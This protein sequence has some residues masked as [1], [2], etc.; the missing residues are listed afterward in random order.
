MT[1]TNIKKLIKYRYIKYK[2]LASKI[3]LNNSKYKTNNNSKVNN[4]IIIE[5]ELLNQALF[6]SFSKLFNI[7]FFEN[8]LT[9]INDLIS[10][11]LLDDKKL[12]LIIINYKKYKRTYNSSEW[13]KKLLNC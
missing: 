8:E 12:D 10:R 9:F 4:E 2:E 1:D 7:Y 13:I 5:L 11:R 3:E 6:I